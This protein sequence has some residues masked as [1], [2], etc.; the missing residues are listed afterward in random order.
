MRDVKGD[1]S[2]QGRVWL[3]E[4]NSIHLSIGPVTVTLA[5]EAFLQTASM[6]RHA[7]EQLAVIV[8]AKEVAGESF[9]KGLE[10]RGAQPVHELRDVGARMHG[11]GT[12]EC[13]EKRC[14][15][16]PG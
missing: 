10:N 13:P 6:V 1:V 4:C 9:A 16:S 11:K 8:A 14:H 2:G 12:I 15:H 3:C 7:M 5:P